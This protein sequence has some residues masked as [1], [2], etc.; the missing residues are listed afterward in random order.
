M[1]NRERRLS[2]R[3]A[4]EVHSSAGYFRLPI[5][6]DSHPRFP[7]TN[8]IL[9]ADAAVGFDI[10]DFWAEDS[11]SANSS[12]LPIAGEG[13]ICWSSYSSKSGNFYLTDAFESILTEVN[14]DENLQGAVVRQYPQ[15]AGS[16]VADIDIAP[17]GPTGRSFLYMLAPRTLTVNVLDVSTA[18]QAVTVQN[19]NFSSAAGEAGVTLNG[20]VKYLNGMATFVNSYYLW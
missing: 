10:F 8:A 18:G 11:L 20:T 12:G 13:T 1:G 19:F 17:V 16:E 15:A 7:G 3:R 4:R 6:S 2:I 5:F 14:V 9:A